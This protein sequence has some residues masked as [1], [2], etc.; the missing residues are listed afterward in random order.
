MEWLSQ[1]RSRL[2]ARL[3]FD[4]LVPRYSTSAGRMETQFLQT[5]FEFLQLVSKR[6]SEL[7]KPVPINQPTGPLILIGP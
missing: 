3:G 5:Y 1:Q 2:S 4:T 6:T 7:S